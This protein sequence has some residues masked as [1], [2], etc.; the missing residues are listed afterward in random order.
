MGNWLEVGSAL[1]DMFARWECWLYCT[2][3]TS[4]DME[5]PFVVILSV[6][7]QNQ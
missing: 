3:T 4:K 2:A 7:S 5:R 6:W 1:H